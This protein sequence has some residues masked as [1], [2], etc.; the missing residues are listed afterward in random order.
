MPTTKD[1][2]KKFLPVGKK[3]P[4]KPIKLSKPL[5]QTKGS[6]KSA[7][8]ETEEHAG[9]SAYQ[10][11]REE[12]RLAAAEPEEEEVKDFSVEEPDWMAA[13]IARKKQKK[14]KAVAT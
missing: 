1:K 11:R 5:S 14:K 6:A 8:M 3:K 12:R 4:D 7:D 13:A 9:E 10:R 2:L